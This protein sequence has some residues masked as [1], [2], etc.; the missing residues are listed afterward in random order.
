[1]LNNLAS[2]YKSMNKLA[3]AE[4]LYEQALKIKRK[5][6]GEAHPEYAI[7]LNN[8]AAL[9]EERK[10]YKK[11]EPLYLQALS[12]I[13]RHL[14]EKHPSFATT[15]NN[16]AVLYQSMGDFAQ[17]E[18]YYIQ[19]NQ[20]LLYQIQYYFPYLNESSRKSFWDQNLRSGFAKFYRFAKARSL[21]N[22]QI[23]GHAYDYRLAT[24]ALLLDGTAKMR[25]AILKSKDD[26]LINQYNAWLTLKNSIAQ[27]YTLS[28]EELAKYGWDVELLE[29]EASRLE[30]QLS[31]Q[32]SH[33]NQ[34]TRPYATT[35]RDVQR[36]LKADEA[37][38]E[39][40][41]VRSPKSEQP[42]Q[43]LAI[44]IKPSHTSNPEL[45]VIE[46][47]QTLESKYILYY[48]NCISFQIEDAI[49]YA[50]FWEPI[51]EK[52]R[53][54]K[55]VYV[56]SDGVY[57]QINLATLWHPQTNKFL[58][59][60]IDVH[61]VTN[62]RELVNWTNEQSTEQVAFLLGHPSYKIN[63]GAELLATSDTRSST[64]IGQWFEQSSF[65]DL[66]GTEE[67]IIK[68]AEGLQ[69]HA[70]QL[71]IK[72]HE[73]ATEEEVKQISNPT[74]LH[75]ATHGFFIPS[76]DGAG[77]EQG[78][79]TENPMLR[80]GLVLAGV[81]NYYSA[82]VRPNTE[83]GILTA[84]EATTLFLDQ[85][86]LV[87]L[88]ACETGLGETKDGEG[89]YGLQRAFKVAG[90]KTILMSLW[91]VND[92]ATQQLMAAF[93]QNWLISKDKRNAFRQAQL[94]LQAQFPEPYYWGAFVMVGE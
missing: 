33:F 43:Y 81:E 70:W 55:K 66:P 90:A 1:S 34:A 77:G 40:I 49:S 6:L 25:N 47:G 35:W 5:Y 16:M 76:Q 52:L 93:Y 17:A 54:V 20:N 58:A 64:R 53:G 50:N 75:I 32:S 84:F 48:R 39:I 78:H 68:I 27:A 4:P 41:R 65:D 10:A 59:Q 83:D 42:I 46:D 13:K 74:I 9:Y 30:T 89:V 82:K 67:E 56:S 29:Q 28:K 61:L 12:I 21:A 8:L 38:V 15:L 22:P 73:Q 72:L 86:E 11:A 18:S 37:A 44:V 71:T 36:K 79:T 94:Q 63:D 69:T 19:A 62:T 26:E 3:E 88:S 87:V 51:A 57:N 60:E 24:K 85:T 91:K 31:R 92:E 45:V 80:S 23:L 2:L 7:S 14:G